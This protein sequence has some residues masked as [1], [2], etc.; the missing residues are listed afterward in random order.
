ME[1][2]EI[3][4]MILTELQRDGRVTSAELAGRVGLSASSALR[5][6]RRLEDEGVIDRYVMLLNPA[7]IGRTVS[8][9]V[10]ISLD[11][12]AEELLDEF[13][14]AIRAAPEVMSCHLMAGDADYLVHVMCVDVADYE[15][16]HRQHLASLPHVARL[17]SSFAIREICNRTDFV[18]A[19]A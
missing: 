16:V 18:I 13:E 14:A 5:R 19:P 7:A 2:D 3:D 6:V 12:Q 15:R 11:S 1:L 17:R 8:V 4:S 9:F 10:E